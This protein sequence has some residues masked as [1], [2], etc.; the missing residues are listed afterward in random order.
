MNEMPRRVFMR[1]HYSIGVILV[2]VRWYRA[3]PLS[4]Q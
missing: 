3:Y 1:L 2:C 4:M